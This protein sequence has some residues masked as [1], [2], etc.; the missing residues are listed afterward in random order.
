[1][2]AG[3]DHLRVEICMQEDAP[4]YARHA[5]GG[6]GQPLVVNQ[7][8]LAVTDGQTRLTG[9]STAMKCG[10]GS[11]PSAVVETAC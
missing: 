9:I 2:Y 5:S 10:A 1:M 8:V 3:V 11:T 7:P 4:K 6:R